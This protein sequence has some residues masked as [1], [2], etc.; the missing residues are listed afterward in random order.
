M[1]YREW[2]FVFYDTPCFSNNTQHRCNCPQQLEVRGVCCMLCVW[3]QST[4]APSDITYVCYPLDRS[5]AYSC[6]PLSGED[7][8]LA[9][10]FPA[11]DEGWLDSARSLFPVNLAAFWTIQ[12]SKLIYEQM[13]IIT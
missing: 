10:F 5:C 9:R 11:K 8:R 1:S 4:H 6:L 7:Q 2:S 13:F 3:E 12:A